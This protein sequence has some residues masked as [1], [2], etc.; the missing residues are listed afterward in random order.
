M[1]TVK[2]FSE[3]MQ[4]HYNTVLSWI[5]KGMPAIRTGRAT[6]IEKEEAIKWLKENSK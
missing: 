5:D 6:R 1:L 2:E 4:V 3:Y